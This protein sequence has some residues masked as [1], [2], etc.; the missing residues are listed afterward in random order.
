MLGDVRSWGKNGRNAD[1]RRLL[2]LECP[3]LEA[4]RT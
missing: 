1:V 4:E 2:D 3:L